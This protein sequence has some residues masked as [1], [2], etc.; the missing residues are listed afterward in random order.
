MY[1]MI[2]PAEEST[3][4]V[5]Q[6]FRIFDRDGNGSIDFKEFMLATDMI[7]C[8]SVEEKLRWAFKVC[9]TLHNV[10]KYKYQNDLMVNEYVKSSPFR[11]AKMKAYLNVYS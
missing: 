1:S 9:I 7:S 3:T 5:D 4:F 8:G 10:N 6:I 2:F 11:F